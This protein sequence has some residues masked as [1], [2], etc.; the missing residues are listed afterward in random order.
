MHA[1]M[2]PRVN[3]RQGSAGICSPLLIS[4]VVISRRI[5]AVARAL[6]LPSLPLL[7][8]SHGNPSRRVCAQPMGLRSERTDPFG[9]LSE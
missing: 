9:A 7:S 4:I 2:R 8:S 1:L 6:R 5:P 3:G